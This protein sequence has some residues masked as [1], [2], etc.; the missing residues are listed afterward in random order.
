MSLRP[1]IKPYGRISRIRLSCKVAPLQGATKVGQRYTNTL[2][3]ANGSRS[4]K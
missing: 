2:S 1:L 3:C 4:V